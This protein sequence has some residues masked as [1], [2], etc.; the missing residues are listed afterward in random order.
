[1]ARKLRLLAA[2]AVALLGAACV[3][4]AHGHGFLWEPQ[5]RNVIT[6][7]GPAHSSAHAPLAIPGVR[8]GAQATLGRAP[9]H[10]DAHAFAGGGEQRG[11]ASA[12]AAA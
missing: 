8:L 7:Q 1:M 2:L 10:W 11:R 6:S 5:A 9:L 4:G 12:Q 3:P